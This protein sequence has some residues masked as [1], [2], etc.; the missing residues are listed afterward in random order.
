M[1]KRELIEAKKK[2]KNRL[3][4][5]SPLLDPLLPLLRDPLQRRP[6]AN[7]ERRQWP[8]PRQRSAR[9]TTSDLHRPGSILRVL[10]CLR[11]SLEPDHDT[12]A[13]SRLDEP[14]RNQRG[15][16]RGLYGGH[17]ACMEPVPVAS[18]PGDRDRGDV[19]GDVILPD[20][21]LS[22]VAD[23]KAHRAVL[24]GC[25]DLGRCC[26][27]G[28]RGVSGYGWGSWFGGVSMDVFGLWGCYGCGGVGVALVVA[29]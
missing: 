22:A 4:H 3:P 11:P 29:R 21:V 9:N 26:R 24:Y 27:I 5:N 18:D 10:R 7:H 23:G 6:G 20:V 2:K 16:D 15:R 17:E 25:A 19:A 13:T 8:R 12:P 28:L 1:P 14:D